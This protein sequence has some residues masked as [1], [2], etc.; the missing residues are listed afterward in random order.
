MNIQFL[1]PIPITNLLFNKLFFDTLLNR[2]LNVHIFSFLVNFNKS[3]T[4]RETQEILE[5]RLTKY[6]NINKI[7]DYFFPLDM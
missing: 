4:I 1:K 5:K 2:G 3:V 6:V 7:F